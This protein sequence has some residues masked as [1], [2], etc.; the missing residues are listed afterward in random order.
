VLK[1]FGDKS[2]K[3]MTIGTVRPEKPNENPGPGTYNIDKALAF[4]KPTSQSVIIKP[5]IG[6]KVPVEVTPSPG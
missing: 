6:F 2:D 1:A 4:V 3:K 5:E